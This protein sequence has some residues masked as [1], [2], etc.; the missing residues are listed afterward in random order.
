MAV[1]KIKLV[2]GVDGEIVKEQ[3]L[4]TKKINM[5]CDFTKDQIA[6]MKRISGLK[7]SYTDEQIINNYIKTTLYVN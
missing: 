7:G 5:S 3:P 4:K 1:H 2:K 6:K